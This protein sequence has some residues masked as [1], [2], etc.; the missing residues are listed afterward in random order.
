VTDIRLYGIANCDQ[1]RAARA[2]LA[3]RGCSMEFID[4]KKNGIDSGTLE[5]WLT[6]LP[7]DS[8]INKR[9]M[10]WR[11]LAPTVRAQIVDQ[12]SATELM[13]AQPL[14]IKRPVLEFGEKMSV[15]FSDSLYQSVF[16]SKAS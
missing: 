3:A 12:H 4:L 15:G 10:T 14:V 9:G 13:L 8:L 11:S 6:H 16:S 1:V 7:W 2:W 5:R